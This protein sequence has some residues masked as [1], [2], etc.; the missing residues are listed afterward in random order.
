MAINSHK[1]K[2]LFFTPYAGYTGSEMVLWYMLCSLDKEKFDTRLFALDKGKLLN[3]FPKH[4][5]TD[6]SKVN[7]GLTRRLIN[8]LL[9]KMKLRGLEQRQIEKIHEEFKPDFWYINT[10]VMNSVIE[11]AIKRNIKYIIHFHELLT[12]YACVSSHNLKNMVGKSYYTVGCSQK[13]CENL[14]TL[15][16]RNIH[17]QYECVNF[18]KIKVSDILSIQLKSNHKINKDAI[19]IVMSGQRIERKGFDIFIE[20]AIRLKEFNYHFLWLGSSKNSGYEF[21]LDKKIN[22]NQL[23][24]ITIIAPA[25]NEYYDYLNLADLFFLTSRED[26]FPLVMIEAAYL[27]KPILSFNSGGSNEFISSKTGF[28]LPDFTNNCIDSNIKS[29]SKLVQEKKWDTTE[30]KNNAINYSSK[31]QAILFQEFL[32]N[33]CYN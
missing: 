18:D 27:G 30:I 17:K 16:A 3:E 25:Q 26:P 22:E 14:K 33:Q 1:I 23:A 28:I 4:I 21:F 5:K 8:K 11:L 31:N 19:I 2:I 20:T 24:N 7:T 9:Q 15:G 6:Y 32:I 13:V 29:I 12:Q 10:M